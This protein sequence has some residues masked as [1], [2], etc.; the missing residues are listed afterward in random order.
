MTAR[1]SLPGAVWR[2][3]GTVRTDASGSFSY[4]IPVGASRTVRFAY[5]VATGDAQPV[6][7]DDVVVRVT[8]RVDLR[9]SRTRLRNGQTL[10]YRGRIRG[11]YAKGRLA[12]IQ[13]RVQRRWRVVCVIRARAHGRFRCGYRFRRTFVPTRYAFRAVVRRQNGFPYELGTSPTRRVRVSPR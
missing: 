7:S 13:V 4:R 2:T 8:S 1:T 10:R 12:E 11:P 6:E 9:L 3:A 5:R